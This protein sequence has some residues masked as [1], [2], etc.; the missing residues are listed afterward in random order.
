MMARKQRKRLA[1]ITK[2]LSP[3]PLNNGS[4]NGLI[5]L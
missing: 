4:I 5:H 1:F 2:P 3:N